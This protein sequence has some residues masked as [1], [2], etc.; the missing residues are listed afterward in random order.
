MLAKA[1]LGCIVLTEVMHVMVKYSA[2]T[3]I[4]LRDGPFISSGPVSLLQM[5]E[6]GDC[7]TFASFHSQLYCIYSKIKTSK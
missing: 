4:L 7:V 6:Y 2:V 5:Y 1:A 3:Y